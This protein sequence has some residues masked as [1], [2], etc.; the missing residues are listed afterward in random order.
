MPGTRIAVARHSGKCLDVSGG[1]AN[2]G[3]RVIQWPCS[4]GNNQWWTAQQQGNFFRIAA[5]AWMRRA[6][7]SS[8]APR[9]FS[10]TAR[11]PT[12]SIGPFATT[13]ASGAMPPDKRPG[14]RKKPG[15]GAI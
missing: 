3:E 7:P 1:P 14:F 13:P 4:G 2:G 9:S 6:H 15:L 10:T 8:P 5:S 11:I 12:I